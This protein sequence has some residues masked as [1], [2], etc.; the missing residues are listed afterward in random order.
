MLKNTL[1]ICNLF[2]LIQL[3][4]QVHLIYSYCI[5]DEDC[6]TG[7]CNKTSLNSKTNCNYGICVCPKGYF[8]KYNVDAQCQ[9]SKLIT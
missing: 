6:L 8:K 4:T 9:P 1:F 5:K 7:F 2:I 3:L